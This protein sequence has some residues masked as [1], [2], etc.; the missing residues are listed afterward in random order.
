MNFTILVD[1][2]LVAFPTIA[3]LLPVASVD[4]WQF[5]E[6]Q[7]LKVTS[8]KLPVCCNL[9]LLVTGNCNRRLT[10]RH[11]FAKTLAVEKSGTDGYNNF[12]LAA[13]CFR[14]VPI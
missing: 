12:R 1:Y 2:Q 7:H 9:L 5:V 14:L 8:G 13:I 3:E 11:A 4:N 10:A 6:V